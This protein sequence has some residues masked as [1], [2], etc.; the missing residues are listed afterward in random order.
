M[1]D[2]YL[3]NI[4]KTIFEYNNDI[5]QK[6][7]LHKWLTNWVFNYNTAEES[8]DIETPPKESLN[9]IHSEIKVKYSKGF[10]IYDED[11]INIL[12]RYIREV[13]LIKP[14]S[15]FLNSCIEK[16]EKLKQNFEPNNSL[17]A[18]EKY[19]NIEKSKIKFENY[20][21]ILYKYHKKQGPFIFQMALPFLFVQKMD[22]EKF[23]NML[24]DVID[25]ITYA[26]KDRK[27]LEFLHGNLVNVNSALCI[28]KT[29]CNKVKN[30]RNNMNV[31][32][33]I[34]YLLEYLDNIQN[35]IFSKNDLDNTHPNIIKYPGILHFKE[36]NINTNNDKYYTETYRDILRG[37]RDL[38]G[39]RYEY[40][41]NQ[42]LPYVRN[43]LF[44]DDDDDDNDNDDND[45]DA[46]STSRS[47]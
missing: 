14:S 15:N 28:H 39:E 32:D 2:Y 12:L 25:T 38:P 44:D 21:R 7:E 9:L 10:I 34:N 37:V 47:I 27:W 20:G 13:Y 46:I 29:F 16:L 36:K 40:I 6:I 43:N 1:A 3:Y 5:D 18:L 26:Q 23:N 41:I 35:C 11:F 8:F 17:Y 45:D 22:K 31:E 33:L 4:L 42:L 30:Y 19:P 24:V